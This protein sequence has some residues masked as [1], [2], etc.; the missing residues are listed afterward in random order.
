MLLDQ[1][2]P[3]ST[4]EHEIY[5]GIRLLEKLRAAQR[6]KRRKRSRADMGEIL[7]ALKKPQ[8]KEEPPSL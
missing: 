1:L 5:D 6:A 2:T 7:K 8:K 4:G 3:S